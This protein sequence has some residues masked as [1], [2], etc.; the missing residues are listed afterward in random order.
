LAGG[1]I[2]ELFPVPKLLIEGYEIL[3]FMTRKKAESFGVDDYEL[4]K[5]WQKLEA[6]KK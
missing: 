1:L 6:L 5:W 2:Q 3:K 4:F